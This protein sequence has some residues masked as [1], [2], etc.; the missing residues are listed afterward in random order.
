MK[1][2]GSFI[3]RHGVCRNNNEVS[4][5]ANLLVLQATNAGKFRLNMNFWLSFIEEETSKLL[6]GS[7]MFSF[8]IGTLAETQ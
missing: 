5:V 6:R 7:N 8:F 1:L 2:I 4:F 3:K